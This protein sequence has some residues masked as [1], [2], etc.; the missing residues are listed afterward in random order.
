[1]T[2]TH[3]PVLAPGEFDGQTTTLDFATEPLTKD[4]NNARFHCCAENKDITCD[5]SICS[6]DCVLNVL[7]KLN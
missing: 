1:M 5:A 6:S 2:S 4:D 3:S 7:C